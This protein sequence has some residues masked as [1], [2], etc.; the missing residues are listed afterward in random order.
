VP[1][2][3]PEPEN[4]DRATTSEVKRVERLDALIESMDIEGVPRLHEPESDL[5]RLQRQTGWQLITQS[6][7]E[8]LTME[9]KKVGMHVD[10]DVLNTH[11]EHA[12]KTSD[13]ARV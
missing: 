9:V 13:D 12:M 7:D 4:V 6:L 1:E 5:K 11:I 8:M 10:G 3:E 2:P